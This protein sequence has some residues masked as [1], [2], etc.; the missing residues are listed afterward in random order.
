MCCSDPLKSQPNV[1]VGKWV[2]NVGFAL[3][4]RTQATIGV[5]SARFRE[6]VSLYSAFD[7]DRPGY[8]CDKFFGNEP[9]R[10]PSETSSKSNSIGACMQP[11][12][13]S[14]ALAGGYYSPHPSL[15]S[16][17]ASPPARDGMH[18]TVKHRLRYYLPSGN[19]H[20]GWRAS[21]QLRSISASGFCTKPL[22][23][24]PTQLCA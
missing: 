9:F 12:N 21:M 8:T 13:S 17:Q 16:V 23:I 5:L 1:A 22:A 15:S 24:C 14:V 11:P 2:A 20:F 7:A 4:L 6:G 19:V 18:M 3:F 10:Q